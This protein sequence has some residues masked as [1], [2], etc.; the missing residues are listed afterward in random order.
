MSATVGGGGGGGGSSGVG[1]GGGGGAP[2]MTTKVQSSKNGNIFTDGMKDSVITAA[3]KQLTRKD[4]RGSNAA[5]QAASIDTSDTSYLDRTSSPSLQTKRKSSSI[6]VTSNG[7]NI[8]LVQLSSFANGN[9]VINEEGG[10]GGGGGGGPSPSS[11]NGD[12]TSADGTGDTDLSSSIIHGDATTATH[13]NNTANKPA[14]TANN[15]MQ[16]SQV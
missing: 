10:G 14:T 3:T 9:P 15:N 1:V 13:T 6:D 4:K 8:D 7:P 11:A 16:I 5:L 2:A 12:Y